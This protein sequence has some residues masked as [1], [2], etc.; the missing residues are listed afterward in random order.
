MPFR[1]PHLTLFDD[2]C[3][4]ERQRLKISI[5]QFIFE[6]EFCFLVTLPYL[7][8]S[9]NRVVVE[10]PYSR[11]KRGVNGVAENDSPRCSGLRGRLTL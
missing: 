2:I 9:D 11:R 3:H 10:A 7:L 4:Y 5:R 8:I 1:R 6:F